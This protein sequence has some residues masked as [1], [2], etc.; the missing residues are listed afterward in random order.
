M[1]CN[2][3]NENFWLAE[4]EDKILLNFTFRL[5]NI[6]A[7]DLINAHKQAFKLGANKIILFCITV[8]PSLWRWQNNL[9]SGITIVDFNGVLTFLKS[10]NKRIAPLRFQKKQSFFDKSFFYFAFSKN[11]CKHYLTISLVLIA[12]S[13]ISFFP[14]YDM[15]IAS[16]CLLASIYS[17]VN[18]RFNPQFGLS[19]K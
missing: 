15:I 7:Q 3:I 18:K 11:R 2:A 9:P 10:F 16:I 6:G 1:T 17:L 13:F 5:S 8:D 12:T 4:G 14:L 19:I